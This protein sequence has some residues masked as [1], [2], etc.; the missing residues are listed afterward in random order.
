LPPS[1]PKVFKQEIILPS[2]PSF[3]DSVIIHS[4]RPG[5]SSVAEVSSFVPSSGKIGRGNLNISVQYENS[6]IGPI[7][8]ET[9]AELK[10]VKA[11]IQQKIGE[12][13]AKAETGS[14]LNYTSSTDGKM[15]VPSFR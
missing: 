12:L 15:I 4:I 3:P 14:K 1:N 7:H 6:F 10:L 8:V 11:V 5:P 9:K 2:S 13:K